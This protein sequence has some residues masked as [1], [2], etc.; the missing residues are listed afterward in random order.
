MKSGRRVRIVNGSYVLAAGL[1]QCVVGWLIL[2]AVGR[3]DRAIKKV[4]KHEKKFLILERA[5]NLDL[6]VEDE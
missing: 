2:R 3:L 6:K 1:C 5:Y 4:E